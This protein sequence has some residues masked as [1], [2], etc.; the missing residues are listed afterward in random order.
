MNNFCLSLRRKSAAKKHR[1]QRR[2]TQPVPTD[3]LERISRHDTL[4]EHQLE[5]QTSGM[6]LEAKSSAENIAN[7]EVPPQSYQSAYNPP[8]RP[9]SK[10]ISQNSV[11]STPIVVTTSEPEKVPNNTNQSTGNWFDMIAKWL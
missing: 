9:S 6:N 10:L 4:E 2:S 8:T 11:D 3:L 7:K 5:Q 1:E